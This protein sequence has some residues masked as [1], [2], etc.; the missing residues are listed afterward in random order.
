MALVILAGALLISASTVAIV[1]RVWRVANAHQQD[2]IVLPEFQSLAQRTYVYDIAGNEIGVFELENSQPINLA[3]VPARVVQAFLSVEDN[4]FR[5]HGGVNVRSLFR[6]TLSNFASDA[7]QQGA[8]TITMQVAK[9][10][11]LAGLE[12]D[13]RYKA[14][15]IVYALRLERD[16]TKEQILERYLNTVY[17]GN[18]AYGIAAAAETYFGKRVTDLSLFEAAFLA[19]LVRSPSGY[20]PIA[21]P[22]RSRAR[23]LQVLARLQ[24]DGLVSESR[25]D[26]LAEGP[27]AFVIPERTRSLPQRQ[28]NRTYFTEAV[29]DY[30]LN[31]SGILGT[32]YQERYNRLFRGGLRIYTTLDPYLQTQA[33]EARDLLPDSLQGFDAALIALD[34]KTAA[35][36]AMVGGRGF[37]AGQRELNLALAPSQTGSSTKIF[38]LAAA[39]LAGAEDYDTVDGRRGCVLPNPGNVDEPTFTIEGGVEGGIF[40]LREHSAR[41]INCA[42]ARLSQIVGLNRVVDLTYRMSQSPYLYRGQPRSERRPIEPFA[43][44]ATGANELSTMDMAA[45]MQT[46]ANGGEHHDPYYIDYIEEVDGRRIYTH[47]ATGTRVLPEGVADLTL[48]ILKDTLTSGTGRAEL[49]RFAQQ[50]PA[51]GKTGTQQDNTVA[52]FV[53]STPYLTTAVLVRDPARYTPMRN[54]AEFQADGVPRVQGG[55]YPARIWGA[56]MEKGHLF[57]PVTDWSPPPGQRRPPAVLY[58]PGVDCLYELVPILGVSDDPLAGPPR[59]SRP[60]STTTTIPGG[61]G[62]IDGAVPP[63]APTTAPTTTIAPPPQLSLLPSG[64]TIPPEITDPRAPLPSVPVGTLTGSCLPAEEPIN[65]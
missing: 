43:S 53:G 5:T 19:G 33:E 64:T 61:T 52:T 38:V 26:A 58:L 32:N 13:G 29:R 31:R 7:P 23:F 21:N 4:E 15:Q 12:R 44:Y 39:I 62:G 17:F 47:V 55:T 1:P 20:D 9:N 56:F 18:N 50:R 42:F 27:E 22:D 11:Y 2:P 16:L 57:E 36:R 45:G 51:A 6:A 8:S 3:D 46:I 10:D 14:L 35:V 63:T 60:T 49:G 48:D 37:I 30:L 54:I 34:T 40:T 59:F 28:V 65:E 41:S 24:S 25:A